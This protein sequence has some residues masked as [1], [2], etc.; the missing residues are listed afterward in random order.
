MTINITASTGRFANKYSQ[1]PVKESNVYTSKCA[2]TRRN[3]LQH[4]Q[5]LHVSKSTPLRRTG[6]FL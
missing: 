3:A 4:I 6:T 1:H 5:K 2:F